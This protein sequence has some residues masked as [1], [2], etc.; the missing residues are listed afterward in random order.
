MITL[1]ETLRD[2]CTEVD[3]TLPFYVVVLGDNSGPANRV[4]RFV[5]D[6]LLESQNQADA[7][8]YPA[9][10]VLNA[11]AENTNAKVVR[12]SFLLTYMEARADGD[13]L[14][15]ILKR[16]MD[17][18]RAVAMR[19]RNG[20]GRASS[21]TIQHDFSVLGQKLFVMSMEMSFTALETIDECDA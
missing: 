16:G 14:K 21:G 6:E 4:Y 10:G 15:P 12:Y 8:Q 1:Y 3:S 7:Q 9:W 13:N 18:L 20:L 11:T 17:K 19:I 5:N 2:Y